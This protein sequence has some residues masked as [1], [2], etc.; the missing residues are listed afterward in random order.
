[1]NQLHKKVIRMSDPVQE[2]LQQLH[3]PDHDDAFFSLIEADHAIVPRLID[4]CQS[5]SD[6]YIRATLIE[7]IWQHRLPLSLDFLAQALNDDHSEVWKAALDG[8]VGIGG[9]ASRAILIRYRDH[10]QPMRKDA[11]IHLHWIDEALQ[12]LAGTTSL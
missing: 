7:I 10:L 1:M 2:Y 12:Q 8:F 4:A 3:Q 11:N 6:P 9:E 5:E